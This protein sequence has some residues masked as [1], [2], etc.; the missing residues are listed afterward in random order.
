MN[1]IINAKIL[2]KCQQESVQKLKTVSEFVYYLAMNF[3]N[4]KYTQQ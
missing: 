2:S 4:N 1:E 3:I